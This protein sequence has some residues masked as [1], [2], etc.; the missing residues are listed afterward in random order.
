MIS[1]RRSTN[2]C[3]TPPGSGSHP[4]AEEPEVSTDPFF[5][6]E[7]MRALR[8]WRKPNASWEDRRLRWIAPYLKG[9]EMTAYIERMYDLKGKSSAK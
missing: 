3:R 4:D 9:P 2:P 8:H 5:D 1:A 7:E 6:S